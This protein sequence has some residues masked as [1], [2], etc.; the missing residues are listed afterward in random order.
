MTAIEKRMTRILWI[1]YRK[2]PSAIILEDNHGVD[3]VE[4][5]LEADMNLNFI[6]LLQD[7]VTRLRKD[8]IAKKKASHKLMQARSQLEQMDAPEDTA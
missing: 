4:F 5:A 1:L 3:A 7:M 8:N 6:G 2:A